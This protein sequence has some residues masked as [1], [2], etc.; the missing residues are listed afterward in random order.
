SLN[1][2][3]IKIPNYFN[4]YILFIPD[5]IYFYD[6]DKKIYIFLSKE[7]SEPHLLIEVGASLLKPTNVS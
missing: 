7:L 2:Q 1:Y 6:N 5:D 3:R 4:E